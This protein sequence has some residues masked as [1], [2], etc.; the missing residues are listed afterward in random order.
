MGLPLASNMGRFDPNFNTEVIKDVLE[1]NKKI[2]EEKE[3]DHPDPK[4]LEKLYMQQL[5][6]G[7][8]LNTR[9]MNN[10]YRPY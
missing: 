1:L 5:Y 3:K 7:M 8:E 6:R 2:K 10:I 4:E 9:S